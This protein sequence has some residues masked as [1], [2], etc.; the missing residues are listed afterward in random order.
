LIKHNGFNLDQ[1]HQIIAALHGQSGKHFASHEFELT[2]DREHLI[3]TKKENGFIEVKIQK[4]ETE[5]RAAN[6]VMTLRETGK[7]DISKDPWEANLDAS[8]LTFPL[9][10][11]KW[12]AGDSFHPLGMDH[13][14]KLSD[15]FIDQKVS[16]ADKEKITILESGNEI[17]WVV[18]YRVDDRYKIPKNSK[19]TML[20][21]TVT[22]SAQ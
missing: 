19:T 12:K 18:G 10:W 22:T 2:I 4:S 11:R 15:F 13:K 17:V 3:V 7:I 21:V 14:K 16:L 8:K 6:Y 5:V 20:R 9:T 1:C